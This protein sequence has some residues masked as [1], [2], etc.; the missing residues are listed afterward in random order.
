MSMQSACQ[1][2]L[3]GLIP[4]PMRLPTYT[5]TETS[6]SAYTKRIISF[7]NT[8]LI[9]VI[10]CMKQIFHSQ[11]ME[12]ISEFSRYEIFLRMQA[13]GTSLINPTVL[14][15]NVRNV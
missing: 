3:N 15:S 9:H 10:M 14:S 1:S 6:F 12:E 8:F 5:R 11:K 13:R 7:I 4:P 2:E